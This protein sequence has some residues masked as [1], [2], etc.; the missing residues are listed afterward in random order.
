MI[1]DSNLN[2]KVYNA[3]SIQ[4]VVLILVL[5]SW[6]PAS[7][8]KYFHVNFHVS[9]LRKQSGNLTSQKNKTLLNYSIKLIDK[10]EVTIT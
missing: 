7:V 1:S 3:D 2:N 9:S 4:L 8:N 5:P 10:S 6:F